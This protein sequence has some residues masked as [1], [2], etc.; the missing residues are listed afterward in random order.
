MPSSIRSSRGMR[1]IPQLLS[2]LALAVFLASA[3]S[4][5]AAPSKASA[6]CHKVKFIGVRGS[7]DEPAPLGQLILKLADHLRLRA[8]GGSFLGSTDLEIVGLPYPAISVDWL[9][10]QEYWASERMGVSLLREFLKAEMASC[11]DEQLVLAGWS[12]GSNVIGD[13]LSNS[14]RGKN[15]LTDNEIDH[16]KAVTLFGDPRFNSDEGFDEGS[17]LPG[18]AGGLLGAR[19]PGDLN[20]V[21]RDNKI[22]SWCRGGD[23]VCQRIFTWAGHDPAAYADLYGDQAATFIAARLGWPKPPISVYGG[24]LDVA[25]V[26]DTT[27]SMS[28]DIDSVKTFAT[29]FADQ[30]SSSGADFRLG[31]VE[32]KDAEVDSFGAQG[33]LPFTNDAAAFQTAVNNLYADGGGDDPEYDLSGIHTAITGLSWRYGAKKTIIVMTD[34]PYKDPEPVGGLTTAAVLQEA[35]NLDPASIDPV[36]IDNGQTAQFQ[37]LADGSNGTSETV[38]D[39]SEVAT[40]ISDSLEKSISAPVAMLATTSPARPGD[41]LELTA[42]GSYDLSGGEI[43]SYEWD[44]DGDGTVDSTT[45]VPQITHIYTSPFSGNAIVTVQNAAG[46]KASATS[47]ISI[48]P[49]APHTPSKVRAIKRASAK[50][51]VLALTWRSPLDNGGVAIVSYVIRVTSVSTHTVVA[52][53]TVSSKLRKAMFKVTPGRYLVSVAA[54]NKAGIGP[55]ASVRMKVA[56]PAHKRR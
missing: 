3:G 36:L 19:F 56:R 2:L 44:F 55:E 1:R 48:E 7:G 15:R 35:R 40:A 37:P 25:F 42:S 31:L 10:F 49:S 32:F 30:M 53:K 26:I 38:T 22:R 4:S 29:S 45:T 52:G 47:P 23:G 12:Q 39:P 5:T 21:A 16:I 46:V 9:H 51:R 17:Y 43:V 50:P 8:P 28:D 14:V 6:D 18:Y 41:K 33:D 27:G 13:V 34:A 54:V 24:K 11:R 20:R